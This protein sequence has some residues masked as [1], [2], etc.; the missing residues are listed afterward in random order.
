M[1]VWERLHVHG[2]RISGRAPQAKIYRF[3]PFYIKKH[4]YSKFCDFLTIWWKELFWLV[5]NQKKEMDIQRI[6]LEDSQIQ[7][8]QLVCTTW[9]GLVL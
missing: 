6:Q 9:T 5:E 3:A 1:Y 2:R 4:L 7:D 8:L